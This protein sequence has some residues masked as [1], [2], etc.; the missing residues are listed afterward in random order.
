MDEK[1]M[2]AFH[3]DG[4]QSNREVAR[5]LDVSEGTIR[6]RLKKLQEGGA[7]AFDV[8]TDTATMGIQFVAFVRAIVEPKHLEAYLQRCTDLK[9]IWYVAALAGRFNAQA[10]VCAASAQEANDLVNRELGDLEGVHQVEIRQVARQI[11]HDYLEIVVQ[12]D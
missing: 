7:I 4:R 8:V 11:K 10:L 3:E 5:K 2:A 9:D 1:I 12:P 6:Q